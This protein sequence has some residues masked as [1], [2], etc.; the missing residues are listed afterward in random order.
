M[1]QILASI[2]NNWK[3]KINKKVNVEESLVSQE[4]FKS[5][6]KKEETSLKKNIEDCAVKGEH[7]NNEKPFSSGS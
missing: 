7:N 4:E 6:I 2:F 3:L 5:D 1:L